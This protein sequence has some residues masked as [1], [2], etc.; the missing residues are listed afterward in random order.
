VARGDRRIVVRDVEDG[1]HFNAGFRNAGLLADALAGLADPDLRE[2]VEA[3][4]PLLLDLYEEVFDHQSFTG[5]SG[6]FYKYEGLGCIYWHMV[7]KLLLAIQELKDRAGL[8]ADTD[9]ATLARIRARYEAVRDG[10]GVHKSPQ[11]HGAIPTD[12]YSH[13][14]GFA[15]AQQPGMTGQVKEDIIARLGEMGCEIA[16]GRVGFRVDLV[17]PVEFLTRPRPFR[18]LDVSG[19][20]QVI[21][22]PVGTLGYTVGQVPVVVH[23]QGPAQ[24]VVARAGGAERVRVPGLTLDPVTSAELFDRSGSI[25]RL[26]VFLDL[27]D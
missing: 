17:R 12:P 9:P 5:R 14:P 7:S 21:E 26:D 10:L 4:T 15:G 18:Y 3:E 16:G 13:T 24:L 1:L 25:N 2:L 6:T 11:L 27:V 23:R 22:L 19:A 8:H 20:V